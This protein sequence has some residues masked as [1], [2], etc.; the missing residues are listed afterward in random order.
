MTR[1]VDASVTRRRVLAVVKGMGGMAGDEGMR[2]VRLPDSAVPSGLTGSAANPR[3]RPALKCTSRE[4]CCFGRAAGTGLLQKR[5]RSLEVGWPS[6]RG[7]V[8]LP[9]PTDI[10]AVVERAAL[11]PAG[12]SG[13]G[14]PGDC[15]SK[16]S[17]VMR[18]S[19]RPLGFFVGLASW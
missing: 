16:A 11:E 18:M 9:P 12:W 4:A 17:A 13:A 5:G 3:P 8:T 19:K 14:L 10:L 7:R 2:L 15:T 1:H 6:V